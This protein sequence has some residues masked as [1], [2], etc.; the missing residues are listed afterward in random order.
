MKGKSFFIDDSRVPTGFTLE[1]LGPFLESQP[2]HQRRQNQP[3]QRSLAAWQE[4]YRVE[5]IKLI[6]SDVRKKLQEYIH[7]NRRPEPDSQKEPRLTPVGRSDEAS[8]RRRFESLRF[9]QDIKLDL[10]GLKRLRRAASQEFEQLLRPAASTNRIIIKEPDQEL[11]HQPIAVP[12][13][14][15]VVPQA[16]FFPIYP[17][18]W[19][20]RADFYQ[21]GAGK[22]I[23]NDSHL[24]WEISRSGS[25]I[26]S[27]NKSAD[28]FD[29]LDAY[30]ENGS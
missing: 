18:W 1:G 3:L 16:A 19:D 14:Q 17:G 8:R 5:A 26:R 6:G 7:Q 25:Y 2:A 20:R 10:T 12:Q 23:N 21:S 9:A 4:K 30:R 13:A 15:T 11:L 28:D 27:K 22:A 29:Y 24:W